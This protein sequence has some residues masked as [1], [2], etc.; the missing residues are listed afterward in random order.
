MH[1]ALL[2]ALWYW[3]ILLVEVV[4]VSTALVHIVLHKR[5]SRAAAY[6][7]ALVALV[8]LL[9]PLLYLL[10][11]INL[12]HRSGRLYRQVA[13][14]AAETAAG[15]MPHELPEWETEVRAM[16]GLVHSLKTVS[17]FTLVGGNSAVL[18]RDGDAAMPA[19]IAAIDN[20]KSSVSLCSYIFEAL[21]V[22]L[23]IIEALERA[24]KRGV[25]V[26]V[27]VDDAGTRYS[28]PNII[29]E[30]KRRNI[31]VRRFMPS[32]LLVRLLTMNL[33][34]HRKIMVVDGRIGF[35]GGM[36]IRQ[37]NMLR[38]ATENPTQ[39]LHFRFE[40]PIVGQMQR[41]F[42]EDWHYCD[43]SWLRGPAWRRTA[44]NSRRRWTSRGRD[45]AARRAR[46]ARGA[47]GWRGAARHARWNGPRRRTLVRG[48]RPACRGGRPRVRSN[49]DVIPAAP[50]P[51]AE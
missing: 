33:R 46:E 4:G 22:G 35:T 20:A 39:D 25:Q 48:G 17:R 45:A 7:V 30:L 34:N 43:G 41:V 16:P 19:M 5:D 44:R 27:I 3:L 1:P 18:L 31:V 21:G 11:G 40:G 2:P 32:R 10:L 26:R 13:S 51:C 23:N 24:M 12:I 28:K 49:K 14:K 8:P 42:M 36:N 38:E 6:W 47:G 9:G 29:G 37:G 15:Y 50:R